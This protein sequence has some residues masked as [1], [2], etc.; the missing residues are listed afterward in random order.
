MQRRC[1]QQ[2]V[3]VLDLPAPATMAGDLPAGLPTGPGSSNVINHVPSR[4]L[5]KEND[6]YKEGARCCAEARS[7]WCSPSSRWAGGSGR[8][9]LISKRIET[10]PAILIF[11]NTSDVENWGYSYSCFGTVQFIGSDLVIKSAM[12]SAVTHLF[13]AYVR[14]VTDTEFNVFVLGRDL[15]F[16]CDSLANKFRT[17]LKICE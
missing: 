1:D 7:A 5:T 8:V 16:V 14:K 9:R 15:I 4:A 11:G 13:Y 12:P 6:P 10:A 17:S 2:P 3:I